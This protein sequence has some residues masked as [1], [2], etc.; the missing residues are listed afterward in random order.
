MCLGVSFLHTLQEIVWNVCDRMYTD[1]GP[2]T[3]I[4]RTQ[5]SK[6][7]LLKL[8]VLRESDIVN[9]NDVNGSVGPPCGMSLK[10]F[11]G[12]SGG[13]P[14][15]DF[16]YGKKNRLWDW[17]SALHGHSLLWPWKVYEVELSW[18]KLNWNQITTEGNLMKADSIKR[19]PHKGLMYFT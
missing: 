5:M 12:S 19:E 6:R 18:G 8:F 17:H 16:L 14:F 7:E 15:V 1:I 13:D 11:L 4:L 2:W 9:L 10:K 3:W